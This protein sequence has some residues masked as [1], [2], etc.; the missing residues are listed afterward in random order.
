MNDR[1]HWSNV[2][3]S[4]LDA[5]VAPAFGAA[6]YR[7]RAQGWR[8]DLSA[9]DWRDRRFVVTGANTGVGFAAAAALAAQG[10]RVDLV[11]RDP[12]RGHAAVERLRSSL[13]AAD[14]RLVLADLSDLG[15]T[16]AGV[17]QLI[18]DPT[19]IDAV[20]HNAGALFNERAMSVDGI[21][22]TFALHVVCPF[23]MTARLAPH[24]H[25]GARVVWVTSGGMYTQR[26]KVD[27]LAAG[28]QRFDGV[29]AY[30]QCKRAQVEVMKRMQAR[31]PG[32]VISAMHP[33][34]ADTR[35]VREALPRFHRMTR[36][37]LRDAAQ[38]AD[39]AVWLAAAEAAADAGGK[40]FLDRAPRAEHVPLAMTQTPEDDV[41]A[42]WAL[43]ER[44]G[45]V[46]WPS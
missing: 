8:D 7:I 25:P 10:A 12:G 33:G 17:D 32:L 1:L 20:I 15:A 46:A 31:A 37:F 45:G 2:V 27:E 36:W 18:A 21:E 29:V 16:A 3:G 40:L 23:A 44:L 28:A 14:L 35:G 9:A 38:G 11:C 6:G 5:M 39:T 30:A 41:D 26:L 22:R 19:P 4:M 42:L 43:C 13:T 24:L 34:W